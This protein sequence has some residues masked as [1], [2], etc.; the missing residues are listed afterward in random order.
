M[1]KQ[2]PHT[3]LPD[4]LIVRTP[5]H[6]EDVARHIVAAVAVTRFKS[7]GQV[8]K[9][10]HVLPLPVFAVDTETIGLNVKS[11]SKSTPVLWGQVL[12]MQVYAGPD[13]NFNPDPKGPSCS[14][15]FVDCAEH[16]L[17]HSMRA[18]FLSRDVQKVR[19]RHVIPAL[20]TTIKS[21][22]GV[23]QLQLRPPRHYEP[24]RA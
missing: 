16:D 3:A 23:P 8:A 24:H 6:A 18:F 14:K 21:C 7:A 12:T 9:G 10:G 13:F 2:L 5:Q 19:Q 4:I 15:L 22:A 20:F 17:L 11:K 1:S